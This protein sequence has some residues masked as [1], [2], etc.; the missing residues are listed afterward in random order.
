MYNALETLI[1]GT[2]PAGYEPVIYV[3]CV[4]FI[5]WLMGQIIGVFVSLFKGVFHLAE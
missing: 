5:M 4:P 1:G 2:I 3:L